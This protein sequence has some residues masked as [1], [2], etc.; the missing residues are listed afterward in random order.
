MIGSGGEPTSDAMDSTRIGRLPH[1]IERAFALIALAVIVVAVAS[2]NYLH[3]ALTSRPEPASATKLPLVALQGDSVSYDFVTLSLGWALYV[4]APATVGQGQFWIFRTRDGAKHWQLQLAGYSSS[5]I[6]ISSLAVES[7][8]SVQFFD[9]KHGFVA[10]GDLLYRTVDEGAHWT[11]TELASTPDNPVTFSDSRHGWFLTRSRSAHDRAPVL[12]ATADGGGTWQRLPD[13]PLDSDSIAF[14][15]P[16]EEWMGSAG[17]GSPHVYESLDGAN[18]WQQHD[19]PLPPGGLPA[20]TL[21]DARVGLL[22][23]AGVVAFLTINGF[24]DYELTSFDGGASWRYVAARPGGVSEA[25]VM[26]FQDAFRWWAIDGGTLY[27]SSDAG[28]TWNLASNQLPMGVYLPH[29][30]DSSHAWA[31]RFVNW[32]SGLDVT[33]DGGLHWQQVTVPPVMSRN[34]A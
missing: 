11:A 9:A 5:L 2:I 30:L 34:A 25:K 3:P 32:G 27:K 13:P 10:V 12:Y 20:D 4:A 24:S 22:Q 29:V 7:S 23:G 21:I 26:S 31:L 8:M 28:Q 16:F 6:G 15:S 17:L 19:L 18:T 33:H 1:R 14:R